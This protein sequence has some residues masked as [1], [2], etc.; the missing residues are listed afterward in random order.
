MQPT[1]DLLL[2]HFQLPL[3]SP[4][5][6]FSLI[7]FII[8]LVPILMERLR[9]PGI[10]GLIVAG[11]LIG[12]NGFNLLGTSLF[13]NVFSTIGLLYIMFLA[14]AELNLIEF[15]ANRN[16]SFV[17]GFLT[18]AIPLGIGFPVC[19]YLLGFDVQASLLVASIFGTH[20]LVTYP[21]AGRHGVT[22]DVSVPITVGGT[23][24]TDTAVLVLLAVLMGGNKGTINGEFWTRLGIS[25]ALF[26]AFMFLLVPRIANWFFQKFEKQK[27]AH[28]IFILAVMFFSAFLA[29]IAGLEGIIGAFAAGLALNKLIPN[30]SALMNRTEFVGNSLFIPFF[31]ISVGMIVDVRV[32]FGGFSAILIAI[33]ITLVAVVG[34]YLAAWLTQ[35]VFRFSR[36]QRQL[37][38]GLSSAHAAA[39]L[40]VVMVGYRAGIVDDAILNGIIVIILASCIIASFVT[41][42]AAAEIARTLEQQ[43]DPAVSRE[44]DMEQILVPVSD[45]SRADQA[46]QL[47]ILIKDRKST[48]PIVVLN[49]VSNSE[50]AEAEVA[51]A[52]KALE[53]VISEAS[54]AEVDVRVKATIA[55]NPARGIARMAKETATDLIILNLPRSDAAIHTLVKEGYESTLHHSDKTV[56][57]CDFEQPIGNHDGLLVIAPPHA[58]QEEG[59]PIWVEK[60]LRLATELSA[61]I[62]LFCTPATHEALTLIAKAEGIKTE[63]AF[64][65]F[66]DWEDF[67]IV[68]R[69]LRDS[70]LIVLVSA[71]KHAASFNP[72]LLH[73][74]VKL[75]KHFRSSSKILIYPQDS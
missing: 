16:K 14:G 66:D 61:S 41:E 6:V 20:T 72:Y 62:R 27:Y 44:L 70:E 47:A 9:I 67:F 54:A 58:E 43:P 26:S 73:L 8:L 40:A 34:K 1:I 32:I 56:F 13:V 30:S 57:V 52:R 4:I 11:I 7:L 19:H 59:F 75:E 37:I 63:I 33:A 36:A 74:P 68:F 21:I 64:T 53:S 65:A 10:I 23:I 49:V 38:F 18:F 29:E 12:P 28:Y 42:R 51:T 48:H 31:L 69:S 39:T 35:L 17:F 45:V 60:L 5:L 3:R 55:V 50:R 24:I 46:L 71:R 2:S 22:K 25:L 15:A